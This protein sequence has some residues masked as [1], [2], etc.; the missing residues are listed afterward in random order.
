LCGKRVLVLDEAGEIFLQKRA[1]K[2]FIAA[3]NVSL[4]RE[5]VPVLQRV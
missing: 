5:L 4:R 1:A 3:D 2:D